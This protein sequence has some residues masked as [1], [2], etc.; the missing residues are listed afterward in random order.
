MADACGLLLFLVRRMFPA[1]R[2]KL[3]ELDPFGCLLFVLRRAVVAAFAFTTGQLND[4]S[5]C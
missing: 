4:V 1:E 2:A 5:H 3:A